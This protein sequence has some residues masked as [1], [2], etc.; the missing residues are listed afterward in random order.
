M[1]DQKSGL[2]VYNSIVKNSRLMIEL[3]LCSQRDDLSGIY[4]APSYSNP[5]TWFGLIY[6]R[7]GIYSTA[8]YRF[9]IIM[10]DA[11]FDPN[12]MK[13]PD[14]GI[15]MSQVCSE[16]SENS[17]NKENL[18]S[19][20]NE[21]SEKNVENKGDQ[22]SQG[23]QGNLVNPDENKQEILKTEQTESDINAKIPENEFK[24]SENELEVT[25]ISENTSTK[26]HPLESSSN[27]E[28]SNTET[29]TSKSNSNITIET[30]NNKKKTKNKKNSKKCNF[31][32][33]SKV[34]GHSPSHWT[35]PR[36]YFYSPTKPFHP[37]VNQET[38]E[39]NLQWYFKNWDEKRHHVWH[40]LKCLKHIFYNKLMKSDLDYEESLKTSNTAD[41]SPNLY[42]ESY[43]KKIGNSNENSSLNTP[44]RIGILNN[45]N[46]LNQKNSFQKRIN[47]HV[48]P[49]IIKTSKTFDLEDGNSA[50]TEIFCL[51][52]TR[53]EILEKNEQEKNEKV[54]KTE[55]ISEVVDSTAS[56]TS[57]QELK[58]CES[59]LFNELA[60]ELYT[61]NFIE[62]QKLVQNNILSTRNE[63]DEY[64]R[65]TNDF[66]EPNYS[67]INEENFKIQRNKMLC[68]GEKM[69]L[70]GWQ[71]QNAQT[72]GHSFI[73]NG[74][75][76]PFSKK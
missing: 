73:M 65:I 36:I 69:K 1:F 63:L 72:S 62:Y 25:E 48:K 39:L 66:F 60:A 43:S 14:G 46:K 75:M 58:S 26:Y 61:L 74:T 57:N 29:S 51:D 40:C 15:N 2:S 68:A 59:K 34:S 21:E 19:K 38:G 11:Y 10:G 53:K 31:N 9:F 33:T 23:N 22:A 42:D 71:A 8:A 13:F 64:P 20:S 44:N 16:M 5:Q 45:F 41:I 28:N 56:E 3:A 12:L 24:I 67:E 50:E 54:D 17:K 76:R 6:I 70:T 7:Y 27:Q 47:D 32:S 4:L 35:L 37:H 18:E 55:S 49:D 52:K 30:D